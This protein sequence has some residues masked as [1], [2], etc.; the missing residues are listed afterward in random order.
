MNTLSVTG[1]YGF[2]IFL[3]MAEK[4]TQGKQLTSFVIHRQSILLTHNRTVN[5]TGKAGRDKPLDQMVE[6]YNL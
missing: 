1:N 3:G 6:H 2:H 4:T 5:T